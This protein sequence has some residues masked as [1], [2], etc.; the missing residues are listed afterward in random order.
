VDLVEVEPVLRRSAD[1]VLTTTVS[2][3]EVGDVLLRGIAE[4]RRGSA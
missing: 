1:L 3:A 2:T 4:L